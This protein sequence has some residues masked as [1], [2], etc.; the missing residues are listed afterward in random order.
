MKSQ[1]LI[2][3]WASAVV[4]AL[5]LIGNGSSGLAQTTNVVTLTTFD[6]ETFD[7]PAPSGRPAYT[8]SYKY[9]WGGEPPSSYMHLFNSLYYLPEDWQYTNAMGQFTFDNTLYGDFITNSAP[10]A[11]YGFGFG[12]GLNW[13]NTGAAFISTNLQDYI[14]SF[15][16]W[17][18]GFKAGLTSVNGEFQMRFDAPDDTIQPADADTSKDTLMQVS[19]NF[20][21]TSNR[22]H[23]VFTLDQGTIADG[24]TDRDFILYRTLIDEPRFGVNFHMPHDG[25]D[26]D[27]D[28]AVY[29]DNI[30]LDVVQA[31]P[32]PPPPPKV[33]FPLFDY[34]WDDKPIWYAWN[35]YP[36]NTGWSA[37][38][39]GQY[40]VSNNV[41]G[42]GVGGSA[43]FMMC[44]DNSAMAGSVPAW[45][46]GNTGGG[47]PVD[48]SQLKSPN[49]ADYRVTLDGRVEGLNP[50]KATTSG[51]MQLHFLAPDDT[52][53]PPDADTGNDMIVRLDFTIPDLM[54]NWQTIQLALDKGTAGAGSKANFT[55]YFDKVSEIQ[56]Q[57]QINNA[58]SEATWSFDADNRM[59]IDNFKLERLQAACPPL[60]IVVNG[61]NLEVSWDAVATGTLQL[62]SATDPGGP[63]SEV[64]GA[65][66]PYVTPVA[67]GP[68]YFRTL[69]I[70][71]SP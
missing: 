17:G 66:S 45:A 68:K 64:V 26:Y 51:T 3:N 52:V 19:R 7:P 12:G 4:G 35:E 32:P 53:Q 67:G 16:A 42:A 44:M 15:D 40:W 34:N 23:Y 43:A 9:E 58:A 57:F 37:G 55:N 20:T 38:T 27:F 30:R 62:Q 59:I 70:P 28:N 8:Y 24:K 47:G 13:T 60:K 25:F 1:T 41:A 56:F 22:Q 46:G 65:T 39:K 48:L 10:G 11:G 54:T 18:E 5:L 63:Y 33:A 2:L 49:L 6:F 21:I 14:V 69:W 36:G 29:I 71:P 61:A 50:T 31:V